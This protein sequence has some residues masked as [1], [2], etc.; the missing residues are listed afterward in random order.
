MNGARG[1]E[2]GSRARAS[3]QANESDTKPLVDVAFVSRSTY[4]VGT[5]SSVATRV[6]PR[7]RKSSPTTVSP[8]AARL[9]V[10]N[11]W[12]YARPR[13]VKFISLIMKAAADG[14]DW[15]MGPR[16]GGGSPGCGRAS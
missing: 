8:E 3:P 9:P 1:R 13:S 12:L 10:C 11:A 16:K 15:V 7:T 14:C 6:L 2:A 4:T 5:T